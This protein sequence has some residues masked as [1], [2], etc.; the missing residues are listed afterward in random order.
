MMRI[1]QS[2][3]VAARARIPFFLVDDTDGKTPEPSVTPATGELKVCKN[4]GAWTNSAGT[5]SN[6]GEGAYDYTPT[7]SE[8]DT[9]G[10][11]LVKV[12]VSGIRINT[13]AAQVQSEDP[14]VSPN[15]RAAVSTDAGNTALT[16]ET[17]LASTTNDFYKG[18]TLIHFT[19]GTLAGQ[20]RALAA[21]NAYNGTTKFI[22][23][24]NALTST[25]TPGDE[26]EL[27]VR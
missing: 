1:K 9:L 2:E 11:I 25:P 21:T 22:T 26:F 27:I 4:G 7:A 8:L 6:R 14:Y 13:A 16:F 5:W 19:S 10:Y 3:S 20:T 24:A 17:T 12:L 23:L 18:P 15:V